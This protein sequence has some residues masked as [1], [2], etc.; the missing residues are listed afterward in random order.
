MNYLGVY[1][2]PCFV[3]H[4]HVALLLATLLLVACSVNMQPSPQERSMV[5]S[6][7]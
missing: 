4:V 2:R 1:C 3:G 5:M 7:V 6:L